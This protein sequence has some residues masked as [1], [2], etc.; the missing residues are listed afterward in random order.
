MKKIKLTRNKF[1][2]IDD[3]SYCYFE[4]HS[5]HVT[6]QGYVARRYTY[7][8][9][10]TK[11]I[12]IHRIIMNCPSGLMVDHINRNSLDNRKSNLR[13]CNKSQNAANSKIAS[14]NTSGYRGV[15]WSK[16]GKKW[17]SSIRVMGKDIYLGYF[18][19]KLD[20]ARTYNKAAEKYF[21]KFAYLNQV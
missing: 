20:A 7:A 21:G 14:N 17:M 16:I 18:F 19:N 13:I 8:K 9:G 11:I 3:E 6:K 5:W 2:I 4:N 15:K 1:T 10:K 12:L